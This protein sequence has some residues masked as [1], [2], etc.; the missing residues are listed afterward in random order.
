MLYKR[1]SRM[2]RRRG[3]GFVLCLELG[4]TSW[5][6][7]LRRAP[8]WDDV[9]VFPVKH[10]NGGHSEATV[11]SGPGEAP[12]DGSQPAGKASRRPHLSGV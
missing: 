4:V 3:R 11:V 10:G 6:A 12:V 2:R 9:A 8:T 1:R 5:R 7:M